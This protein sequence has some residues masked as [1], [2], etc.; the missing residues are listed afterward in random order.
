MRISDWSSD[1]CSSDLA[2][3]Q[4]PG[5]RLVS[6]QLYPAHR[7]K[8]AATGKGRLLVERRVL[9][10]ASPPQGRSPAGTAMLVSLAI[11][12]VVLIDRLDLEFQPGL[13][14]LTGETG[15]RKSVV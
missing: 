10:H 12:D 1:V 6:G 2:R 9:G 13:S 15:D 5:Q 7:R 11:R 3:L 8:P 14:A 4:L